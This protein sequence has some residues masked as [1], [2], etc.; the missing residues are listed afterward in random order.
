VLGEKWRGPTNGGGALQNQR[1]GK[2]LES[3]LNLIRWLMTRKPTIPVEG[4]GLL[5]LQGLRLFGSSPS[6]RGGH[7]ETEELKSENQVHRGFY[8]KLHE[9]KENGKT[10]GGSKL[11]CITKKNSTVFS[12]MWDR[13]SDETEK[14]WR[15]AIKKRGELKAGGQEETSISYYLGVGFCILLWEDE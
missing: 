13:G 11:I 3:E 9:R 14:W 4:D 6:G 10:R 8:Q 5:F 2:G 7:G 12:G 15:K 1:E